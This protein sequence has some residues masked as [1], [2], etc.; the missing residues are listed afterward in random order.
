MAFRRR[1]K[2]PVAWLPHIIHDSSQV[3][4]WIDGSNNVVNTTN[5]LNT[6]IHSLTVDYP[7]EGIRLASP[8][9]FQTMADFEA[10]AYR[11]RRLV[12]KIFIGVNQD[13]AAAQTTYPT[14]VLVGAGFM[15]LRVDTTG[16]PL[17]AATAPNDYSP[18]YLENT[19]DPWIWRRT[20]LLTNQF[21]HTDQGSTLG[22]SQA[23]TYNGD[24]GSALDGPHFD[25]KTARIVSSEERLFF[26]M[27]TANIGDEAT[28]NGTVQWLLDY[29][30]L[31]SPIR[32]M[33]NR[34]NASR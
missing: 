21:G 31:G 30:L 6:T 27:S 5:T 26:I 23:P 33:G 32:K 8:T 29:R 13:I 1:R 20:W 14:N 2:P 19:R 24:Y 15:V 3:I 7:A 4:G 11:L 12:G 34:R 16:A 10:S 28:A 9:D 25:Q 17:R 18:L 22:Y